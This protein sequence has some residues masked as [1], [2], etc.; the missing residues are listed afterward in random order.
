MN[1]LYL[2]SW[3]HSRL[4]ITNKKIWIS[5][6]FPC[7][8]MIVL[9]LRWQSSCQTL[10]NV[11][12]C[13]WVSFVCGKESQR[14]VSNYDYQ[15][16]EHNTNQRKITGHNAPLIF[17]FVR[18]LF[19]LRPKTTFCFSIPSSW[20]WG[21]NVYISVASFALSFGLTHL[22]RGEK[23]RRQ[24]L[25]LHAYFQSWSTYIHLISNVPDADYLDTLR[26][27]QGWSFLHLL[28]FLMLK[29]LKIKVEVQVMRQLMY[30][31]E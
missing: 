20:T 11:V 18:S 17:D 31:K 21:T 22:L 7:I 6:S 16:R 14:I 12:N 2:S 4:V 27:S 15:T 1:H 29:N 30:I 26:R 13:T 28:L 23:F 24:P 5:I 25:C 8:S 3:R 9:K 19:I 10:N